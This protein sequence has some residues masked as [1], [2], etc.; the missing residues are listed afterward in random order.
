MTLP[1]RLLIAF[2]LICLVSV[3]CWVVLPRYGV[4]APPGIVFIG[5]IVILVSC[6]L[7]A[8]PA[9]EDKEEL[10]ESP[11]LIDRDDDPPI[12]GKIGPH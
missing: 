3:A 1:R 9:D 5:Y 10:D 2:L 6:L 11:Q 7:A 12:A 4:W 8:G